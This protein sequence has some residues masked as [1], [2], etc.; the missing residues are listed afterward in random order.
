MPMPKK[1]TDS[2]IIFMAIFSMLAIL[3]V[4]GGIGSS[5]TIVVQSTVFP[6]AKVSSPEDTCIWELNLLSLASTPRRGS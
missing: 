3:S 1:L 4:Q 2:N 6:C 5:E